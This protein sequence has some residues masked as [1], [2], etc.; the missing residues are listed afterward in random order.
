MVPLPGRDLIVARCGVEHSN[1][2]A[3]RL[4]HI[5]RRSDCRITVFLQIR[6]SPEDRQRLVDAAAGNHLDPST[7]ARQ[8]IMR[9]IEDW[10][11]KQKGAGE[12]AGSAGKHKSKRGS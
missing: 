7:W 5:V 11:K 8:I 9:A 2:G 1:P 4:S 6:F 3:C 10:E 12:K